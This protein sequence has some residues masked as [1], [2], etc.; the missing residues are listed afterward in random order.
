MCASLRALGLGIISIANQKGGVGKTITTIQLAAGLAQGGARVLVIDGDPQGNLSLFFQ[1]NGVSGKDFGDLLKDLLESGFAEKHQYI[2]ASVRPGLDLL[3]TRHRNLRSEIR[4]DRMDVVSPLFSTFLA[5]LRASYD[6]I[7]I[8]SSPSNGALERM[9]IRASEAILIPL[10]FQL[11]SVAGLE[12]ILEEVAACS[13]EAARAIRIHGL[14]FTKAENR[15]KRVDT[16]RELFSAFHIPIFEVCKSEYIPRS[17]EKTRTI[18]E[19][20]PESYVARDYG[21]II[22]RAF[23]A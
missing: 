19:V 23:L 21:R 1:P 9:L 2:H 17:I 6:W 15:L 20:A 16:Y 12:A 10:E 3:P 14:I 4:D 18:W 13:R 5:T 22:E 7:L 8:D 11:F